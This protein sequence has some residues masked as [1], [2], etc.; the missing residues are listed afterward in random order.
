[1]PSQDTF[2]DAFS[3]YNQIQIASEDEKKI[4]F[5]TDKD[6]YYYKMILFNLKNIGAT[7]QHLINKI[8]K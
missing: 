6:L 5:I 4:I 7:Y 2:I 8:S 3:R 1:M